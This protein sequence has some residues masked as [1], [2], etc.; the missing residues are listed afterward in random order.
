MRLR[1]TGLLR[2]SEANNVLNKV[3]EKIKVKVG[4]K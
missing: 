3:I 2:W 1:R 4:V